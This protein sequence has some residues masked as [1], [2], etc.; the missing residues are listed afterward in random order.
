MSRTKSG[1][2]GL[3]LNAALMLVAFVLLGLAIWSNREQL[4]EVLFRPPGTPPLRLDLLAVAFATYMFALTSTFYRWYLLVRALDLPFRFRDALRLGFIG[5]V[6]NLVVPGAIGGDVIKGAY[7]CREQAR[8]TQ[9]VSSMVIDR[10]LGLLGLFLL[11]GMM[12]IGVWSTASPEVRKLISIVW[13]AS[14]C[15]LV[16]LAILF[17]PQLYRPL[18][19]LVAGRRRLEGFVRELFAMA[20]AYRR[21]LGLIGVLLVMSSCVHALHVLAFYLVSRAIFPH[22][23]PSIAQHLLMT[24]LVL[25]TT[26]IP[27]PFGA[28]GVSEQVSDQLFGLVGHPGG[29]VAMMGFRVLM[30]GG[31]LVSLAVYVANIRQVRELSRDVE[32]SAEVLVAAES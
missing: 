10:A 20:S 3:A 23:V 7:L 4:R 11:A 22:D 13:T 17:T 16:G 31:G 24:P 8:K 29:A 28:L 15:G 19:R 21:R 12:G 27:I 6:F 5:N 18:E 30:Y 14:S 26:A 9:A 25:F 1:A 2:R 32:P